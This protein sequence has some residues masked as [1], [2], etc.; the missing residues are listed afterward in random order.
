MDYY[1]SHLSL[2]LKPPDM[3][4]LRNQRDIWEPLFTYAVLP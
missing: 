2:Q 3:S 1:L 4:M